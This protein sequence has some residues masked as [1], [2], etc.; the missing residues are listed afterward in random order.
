MATDALRDITAG[1]VG[2]AA[3]IIVGNPFDVV[4]TRAQMS[5]TPPL[6]EMLS[7]LRGEGF[8]GFWKGVTP[9]VL[10]AAVYQGT[11]FMSYKVAGRAMESNP[12]FK[13]QSTRVKNALA[14]SFA[15]AVC[16]LVV[17]PIDAVKISLQLQRKTKPSWELLKKIKPYCGLTATLIRDVPSTVVYFEANEISREA[18]YS[19]FTSGA[20]A[21]AM[22]WLS[23]APFDTIKTRVQGQNCS[24]FHATRDIYF[25][26]GMRGFFRGVV[27]LVSRSIPVNGVTFWVYHH[28]LELMES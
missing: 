26:F 1:A 21:G 22:S 9:P 23:C 13:D 7:V 14:G 16:S 24:F 2:G 11:V 12:A 3:G 28:L 10:G 4:K 17:T 15:G 6:Q 19:V 25:I 18:G 27:P 5:G 8:K 20:V